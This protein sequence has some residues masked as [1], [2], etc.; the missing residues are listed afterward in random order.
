[1]CYHIKTPDIYKDMQADSH[2][3]DL[4]DYPVGHPLQSN[5]N[6]KAIGYMKVA[7]HCLRLA[8]PS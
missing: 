2:L 1:M 5:A 8:N 3:Y 6:K 4:S 7:C